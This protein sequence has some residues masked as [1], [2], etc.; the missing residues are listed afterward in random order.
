VSC[1][2]SCAC[3]ARR[4]SSRSRPFTCSDRSRFDPG[5]NCSH[6]SSDKPCKPDPQPDRGKDCLDHGQARGNEDHCLDT[7]ETTDT[8]HTDTTDTTDTHT[9]TTDTHTDTTD[10]TTHTDTTDPETG[11]I[12]IEKQT[13][14]DGDQTSFMFSATYHAD[15]F[16][17]SDGESNDSGPLAPGNYRVFEFVPSGWT[18]TSSV[19]TGGQVRTNINLA[20]G[21]TVKCVV[22]NTKDTTTHTD[23]TDTDHTDTTVTSHGG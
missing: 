15:G 18:P 10:T 1:P 8:T 9:D 20:A 16:S 11:R 12:I 4:R 13:V 5:D 23:T 6:G 14:P 17:L 19:C 3:T 7:T 21:E 22:T 2:D